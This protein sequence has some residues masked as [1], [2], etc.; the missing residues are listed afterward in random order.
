V[1]AAVI[2]MVSPSLRQPARFVQAAERIDRQKFIAHPTM[3]RLNMCVLPGRTGLGD[4]QLNRLI[5]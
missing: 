1:D 4:N 2:V 3:K 5:F